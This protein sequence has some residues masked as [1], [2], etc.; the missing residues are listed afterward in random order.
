[1]TDK[2]KIDELRRKISEY[3]DKLQDMSLSDPETVKLAL[4][5][6]KEMEAAAK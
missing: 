2:I 5:A 4:K 6:E 1:M 3:T